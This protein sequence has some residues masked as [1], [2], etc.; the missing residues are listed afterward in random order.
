MIITKGM[1]PKSLS[2]TH[3]IIYWNTQLAKLKIF[4]ANTY[5]LKG[6][7]TYVCDCICCIIIMLKL[8]LCLI[9]LGCDVVF[10]PATNTSVSSSQVVIRK[11]NQSFVG[12]EKK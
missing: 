4:A 5:I 3:R 11:K 10:L 9:I 12:S 7:N 6:A 2:E 1:V 8:P